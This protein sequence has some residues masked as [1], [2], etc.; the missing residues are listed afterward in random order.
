MIRNSLIISSLMAGC[1]F[2]TQSSAAIFN[3]D[4]MNITGGTITRNF[5]PTP[6]TIN[7]GLTGNTNLVGSYIN[8]NSTLDGLPISITNFG[9]PGSPITPPQYVY[10]AASNI[11]HNGVQTAPVDGIPTPGDGDFMGGPIPT[12]IVDD[13]LGTISMDLSSWFANHM[14]MDQNLGSANATGNWDANTGLYDLSWTAILTQGGGAGGTVTWDLQG[15][16]LQKSAASVP[17]PSSLWLL[18]V[19]LLGFGLQRIRIRAAGA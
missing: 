6:D 19:S 16:V 18:V 8:K 14:T 2:S 1:V 10:T 13:A 17:E 5:L 7:L 12:G 4:E 15:Q 11:N 9:M 3:I